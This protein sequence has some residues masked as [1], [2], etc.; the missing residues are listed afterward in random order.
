M[1]LALQQSELNRHLRENSVDINQEIHHEDLLAL[2][3]RLSLLVGATQSFKYESLLKPIPAVFPLHNGEVDIQKL[4]EIL[5]ELPEIPSATEDLDNDFIRFFSSAFNL[6]H[7][8]RSITINQFRQAVLGHVKLTSYPQWV[9]SINYSAG[10]MRMWEKMKC[11]RESFFAFHGSR[12]ENF[13]AILNLG[14]HQ[15]LNK[16]SLFGEGIY[17]STE[18][19]LSLQYSPS[20]QGWI[21]SKLGSQLSILALCEVIDHPN[22]K[23][24]GN[25]IH[26]SVL[27]SSTL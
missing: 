4:R 24:K 5:S 8:L 9:F 19:S 6:S 15:H 13:H 16:T 1:P 23:R 10:R 14:L 22:V 3:L 12:F 21:K 18:Q 20:G 7:T 25:P 26:S 2:D 17:L 27:S 11:D